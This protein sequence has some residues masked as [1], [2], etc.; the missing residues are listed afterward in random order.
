VP[1]VCLFE[2]MI[3]YRLLYTACYVRWRPI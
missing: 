1:L 3:K 2:R